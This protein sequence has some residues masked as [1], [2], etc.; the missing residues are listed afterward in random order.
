MGYI[1]DIFI[2][3]RRNPETHEWIKAHFEPLLKLR[4]GFELDR[5]IDV[6]I[7]DRLEIGASCQWI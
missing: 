5:D 7:D 1:H 2:S 4:V 6:F 3:Y